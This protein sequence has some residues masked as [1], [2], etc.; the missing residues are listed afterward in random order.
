MCHDRSFQNESIMEKSNEIEA[1]KVVIDAIANLDS[2][3]QQRV[4]R[5]AAELYGCTLQATI[6]G[7]LRV[8]G[9]TDS[10]SQSAVVSDSEYPNI[11][12]LFDRAKPDAGPGRALV[13]AYWFEVCQ[14]NDSFE[15]A[16]VNS[17]LKHLGYRLANITVT[18]GNLMTKKPA[19][20]MQVRKGGKSKQARKVYKLTQEGIR[21]V[22]N[23]L[24]PVEHGE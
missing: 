8:S 3:A 16:Q 17:E 23:M 6:Q 12:A 13:A 24:H 1:V 5:A 18:L 21:H 4:L 14:S 10:V 20:V 2:E 11:A 15:A 9:S 7:R 22:R 19:L